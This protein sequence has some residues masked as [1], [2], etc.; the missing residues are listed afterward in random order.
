[1]KP[2][3]IGGIDLVGTVLEAGPGSPHTV[4]SKVLCKYLA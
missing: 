4:G 3:M 2:P 1:M